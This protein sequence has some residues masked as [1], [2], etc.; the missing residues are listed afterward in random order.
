LILF[1]SLLLLS[2][3]ILKKA[4]FLKSKRIIFL[5]FEQLNSSIVQIEKINYVDTWYNGILGTVKV[6]E[7]IFLFFR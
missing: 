4:L 6:K 3:I 1:L 2:H 7:K 5:L